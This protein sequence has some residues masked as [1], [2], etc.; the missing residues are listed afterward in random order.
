[1]NEKNILFQILK[2][3]WIHKKKYII[4]LCSVLLLK[5][6]MPFVTLVSLQEILNAAQS[7]LDINEYVFLKLLI[8]Y[9]VSIILGSLLDNLYEYIQGI[10]KVNLNY[11]F[12]RLIINKCI[13]LNL[14]EYE[15]S[16]TYDK[17]QRAIQ[18]TQTPYQCI[19]SI[20]NVFSNA[21]SLFGHIVIL[22]M[23][24][25]YVF[26][27]LMF[28]PVI[29]AIFAIIIGKYEY[30]V[31]RERAS[32]S[33]KISYYRTLISDVISCKENKILNIENELFQRFNK[34]YL[35]FIAKD[36]K[37]LGYKVFNS[38]LF[39]FLQNIIGIF[40]LLRVLV[41]VIQKKIYIGTASTYINCVWNSIK[42][43]NITIDNIANIYNKIRYISNILNFL[44][45]NEKNDIR[46]ESL[47]KID[48]IRKIEFYNV[49]FRYR[50]ELP[51]VLE[52]INCTINE[53]DKIVIVGGNG[54]GKST[55]IKLLCGLYD[56]YEG[57]ILINGLSLR[58]ID[59]ISYRKKLGVVFQDY[60]KYE[61]NLRDSLLLGNG[62]ILE[63]EL[64][65]QV[66]NIQKKGIISFVDKLPKGLDTTL[67]S[68]FDKGIQL[69]GGEWQQVS[70]VRTLIKDAEVCIFDEPSSALD[71]IT[72]EN[73]YKLLKEKMC[74]S[75]CI[76]ITHRLY[77]V[78]NYAERAIVFKGGKIIEDGKVEELLA[79][80]S[81]YK[82]M[83]NKIK[84]YESDSEGEN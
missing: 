35:R 16:E 59:K 75:I 22:F 8:T 66:K 21:I 42:S 70:F 69:S 20:F 78:N 72:E 23:W 82:Q 2:I 84:S 67:G 77:I 74:Q 39:N 45:M 24:K 1:M 76:L 13:S 31:M 26:F 41:E 29:S 62:E 68:K 73:M 25:W 50:E 10:L 27:I 38:V 52:K 80:N 65:F 55:F 48:K 51:Y 5:T 17:M 9:F 36:K 60:V 7:G 33:R 32:D 3:C 15:D 40:I 81:I 83:F 43:I 54:S 47:I 30:K 57:D 18:E 71:V 53:D 19:I 64:N 58:S 12:H 56:E 11:E 63:N 34:M 28:V 44:N 37:I 6:V 61:F 49:S 4:I 79:R 46:N 14:K